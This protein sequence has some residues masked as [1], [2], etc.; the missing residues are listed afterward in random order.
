MKKLK[1]IETKTIESKAN[2]DP[3]INKYNEQYLNDLTDK[4][5]NT[6]AKITDKDAWLKEVRGSYED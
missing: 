3:P 4:A 6:W 5:T 2:L 1:S